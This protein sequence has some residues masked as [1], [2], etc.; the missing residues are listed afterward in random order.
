MA[1]T[2]PTFEE[3]DKHIQTHAAQAAPATAAA[4]AAAIPNVCQSYKTIRPILIALGSFPFIPKKWRDAIQAFT[5]V[6]D[7]FCPTT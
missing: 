2:A 5:S 1:N 4:G 7:G 3:I 6:M